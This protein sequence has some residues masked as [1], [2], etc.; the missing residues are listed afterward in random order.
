[1]DAASLDDRGVIVDGEVEQSR[2][3]AEAR[4]SRRGIEACEPRALDKG[5]RQSMF[6][7]TRPN[8]KNIHL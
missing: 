7:A 1:M 2:D 8:Q 5:Q 6:A 4:I 3:S